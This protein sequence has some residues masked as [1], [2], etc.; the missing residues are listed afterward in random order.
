MLSDFFLIYRFVQLSSRILWKFMRKLQLF[1]RNYWSVWLCLF[2]LFSSNR[3]SNLSPIMLLHTQSHT[4]CFNNFHLSTA[5]MQLWSWIQSSYMYLFLN[6]F[7]LKVNLNRSC[8]IWRQMQLSSRLFWHSLWEF[9]LRSRTSRWSSL[10]LFRLCYSKWL[11][12]LSKKM[13]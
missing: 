2:R 13:L 10:R 12:K 3:F 1:Y 9:R 6:F 7:M 4:A 8:F 11:F 5:N